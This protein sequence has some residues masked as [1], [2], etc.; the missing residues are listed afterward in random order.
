MDDLQQLFKKIEDNIFDTQEDNQKSSENIDPN[1]PSTTL[2]SKS[3]KKSKIRKITTEIKENRLS[4]LHLENPKEPEAIQEE[5]KDKEV[6]LVFGDEYSD[7]GRQD[8]TGI[9][10]QIISTRNFSP[11]YS[12]L[13]L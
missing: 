5:S 3:P 11:N 8:K 7:Y 9:H 1:L 10:F 6:P 13:N 2:E 4:K 12:R